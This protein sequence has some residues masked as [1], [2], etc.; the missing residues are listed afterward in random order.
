MNLSDTENTE[1]ISVLEKLP[2]HKNF[3]Q[4]FSHREIK[5]KLQIFLKQYSGTLRGLIESRK[6]AKKPFTRKEIIKILTDIACGLN[7]LHSHN[8]I[9]RGNDF[10]DIF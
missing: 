5:G 7:F 8:V 3:V 1:E 2:Y 4:Y 10:L 6:K 9:H